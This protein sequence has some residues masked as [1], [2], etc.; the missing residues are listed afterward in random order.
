MAS[1]YL[2]TCSS[3]FFSKGKIYKILK[4]IRDGPVIAN[5]IRVDSNFFIIIFVVIY[6]Y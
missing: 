2:I 3:Y 5:S 1:L 6:H 4:F